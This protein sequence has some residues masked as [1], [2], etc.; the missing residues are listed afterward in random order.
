MLLAG[1]TG[2]LLHAC[3]L[4]HSTCIT[5]PHTVTPAPPPLPSHCSENLRADEGAQY[6][7]IIEINLSELE[8]QVN[9]P[10]TPDLANPLSKLAENARREGWP[11]Q[12]SGEAEA[13]CW[14]GVGMD[15]QAENVLHGRLCLLGR[16]LPV[17]LL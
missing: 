9:G 15:G 7:Q 8:P 10:F 2:Q 3:V 6:D 1:G 4:A 14:L 17:C 13:A 5:L 16:S 12:V 11:L